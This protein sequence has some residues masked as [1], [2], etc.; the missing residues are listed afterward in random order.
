[1]NITRRKL[2]LS[3]ALAS[4]ALSLTGCEKLISHVTEEMGQTLPDRI[5]VADSQEIDY[6]F[7]LLSRAAYGHWPGDLERVRRMGADAWI[8]EQLLPENIDDTLCDL[9]ARRFETIHHNP[10][11]CYEYKKP[12]LRE[13]IARHTLLRAVYSRRQLFEVMVGFWTDHL[14]INLEKGDCIYL[15]PTDDRQ[16]IRAHALGRFRDLIRA[17]ATSPAM[18]VYLDGNQNK[19][20]LPEDIPNENYARELLELHTVGV[21]GGYRQAD[22]YEIAR[23]LTGWQLRTKWRK[24][25]IYFD[26]SLH[27]DGEKHV[28]GHTIPAGGGES[29]LDRV[30][31][32]V[33]NHPS[34][35][36]FISTKLVRRFVSDDP[37]QSLIEGAAKVF[38]QTDGDIKSV[39][40]TILTSDEFKSSRGSKFKR[41]FHF[42]VSCLRATAADTHAHSPLIE[43]LARMGQGP[44]QHPTPDGYPDEAAPWLGTLLWRWNF[45]FALAASQIPSVS[46]SI[47]SLASAIGGSVDSGLV[48]SK[49]LPHFIGRA[50]TPQE[51]NALAGYAGAESFSDEKR[52]AELLGLVLASPA[53]QRY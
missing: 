16:V 21:R 9:R 46:L 37:P 38:A 25:T 42:I 13:E 44:F 35:A 15:K 23:C 17:S 48:P 51:V 27:D 45:A 8:E 30:I 43:Y 7:H 4:G 49:L 53:F 33:C 14:N 40:R 19:K 26:S 47:E 11:T 5:A 29:D 3:A 39:L 24:G 12:V 2:I 34:T 31:D 10:G 41:P 52:R 36:K 6:D 18:L 32:I 22:V 1:M 28:L 20:S 50:G